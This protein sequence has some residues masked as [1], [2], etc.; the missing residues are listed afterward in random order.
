MCNN[1]KF[2]EYYAEHYAV[3][4]QPHAAEEDVRADSE[5]GPGPGPTPSPAAA[6]AI[7]KLSQSRRSRS[8]RV[9]N[10]DSD[11]DNE[12]APPR[13][14]RTKRGRSHADHDAQTTELNRVYEY[15]DVPQYLEPVPLP[16]EVSF[17]LPPV[18]YEAPDAS[19]AAVA[20]FGVHRGVTFSRTLER[21]C[22]RVSVPVLDCLLCIQEKIEILEMRSCVL[23][24]R[25]VNPT[26]IQVGRIPSSLALHPQDA[27]Q[28]RT[29][30]L[31]CL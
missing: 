5:V 25:I 17:T 12:D 24:G 13:H 19:C 31:S 9:I 30:A 7:P 3:H 6:D 10:D 26:V 29:F 21:I 23:C 11:E 28:P 14:P 18:V 2:D 27:A 16:S 20:E 22:L 1:V 15:V 8:L 4:T